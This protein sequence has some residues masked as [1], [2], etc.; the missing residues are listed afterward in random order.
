[1]PLA[2]V[3]PLDLAVV[4]GSSSA[5]SGLANLLTPDPKE[6]FVAEGAGVCTIALDL[7]TALT[8]DTVL[9]GYTNASAADNIAVLPGLSGGAYSYGAFAHSFRRSPMRHGLVTL[10]APMTQRYLRI[11][12]ATGAQLVAGDAAVGLAMRPGHDL[13]SGRPVSDTGRTERTFGGSLGSEA[14][15]TASGWQWTMPALTNDQRDQLHA[16]T[17]DLGTTGSALVVEDPVPSNGLNERIH[18]GKLVLRESFERL[19]GDESK[20]TMQI[21]DWA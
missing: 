5:G 18:W 13:G 20:W 19:S 17:L 4:A 9:L 14:G 6:A 8:F 11:Y 7:G 3:H 1:M 15:T 2:I 12:T 21:Q 10:G 16:M